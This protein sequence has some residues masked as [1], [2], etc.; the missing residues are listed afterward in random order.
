MTAV[1][2]KRAATAAAVALAFT[3]GA[4]LAQSPGQQQQQQ[5]RYASGVVLVSPKA[6]LSDKD[7]DKLLQGQRGQRRQHWREL[8]VHVVEVPAGVDALQVAAT[9]ARNP[10]VKFAQ[11]DTKRKVDAVPNDPSYGSAWHLPMI[12]APLAWDKSQGTGVTVAVCD[13]GV[14]PTHPDLVRVPGYNMF[15]GNTNTADVYGHGTKVAG[16]IAMA[17]A[18]GVGGAGVAYRTKI[19]PIRVTDSNGWGYD[20]AIANCI[21]YAADMG[22]RGAN[23]S[24]GG[25]CSSPIIQSAAKYMRDR[26]GV[27]TASAGNTGAQEVFSGTDLMTCVSAT[28]SGDSRT[29]WS[30]YGAFVDVAAPGENIFTTTNG[31]GYGGASGTSFAAPVTLGVYALMMA[32]NPSLTPAALD[33]ILFTT[34]KDLGTTGKDVQFGHGRIDA[35][36]AVAKAAGSVVGDTTPPTVSIAGPLG[37][38]KVSGLVT[39]DVS[40]QDAGGVA[41]VELIVNGKPYA[42][43]TIGPFSFSWDTAALPD[44]PVTLVA[45]AVDAAGNA[46]S[47]QIAVT[48]AN[49]KTPPVAQI[50]SP[51]AGSAVSGTVSVNAS[52]TD[53]N[54]V[55]KMTLSIDGR[56]VAVTYGP[57]VSFSWSAGVTSTNLRRGTR[58]TQTPTTSTITVVAEDQAGNRGSASQTVTRQ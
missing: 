55:A 38:A 21:T 44:G 14:D 34:A 42:T 7:L 58:R 19:M 51:G 50:L 25:V 45:K 35:A 22:A 31:G 16:A 47:T 28:N 33:N 4:A 30:T 13:S 20:S 57:A 11:V 27:V 23:V 41:S 46:T 6:G 2:F 53:N 10:H 54:K 24:F 36:A 5:I 15:D 48:V 56:E 9:L 3:S 32:A 12:G 26:G 17:G 37:G 43:D 40:A 8:N 49:D 1:T 39:V 52:A 18:N 29:S